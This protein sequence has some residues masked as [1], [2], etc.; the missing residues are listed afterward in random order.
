MLDGLL[1]PVGAFTTVL[2]T[3]YSSTMLFLVC[4]WL[5]WGCWPPSWSV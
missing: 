2:H 3:H 4:W 5:Q 1:I